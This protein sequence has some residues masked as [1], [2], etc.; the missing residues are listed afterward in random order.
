[1]PILQDQRPSHYFSGRIAARRRLRRQLDRL[2]GFLDADSVWAFASGA[3]H[4]RLLAAESQLGVTLPWELWELLRR[5]N[6]Q[7][8]SSR[9]SQFVGG[10]RLLSLE[11][12]T[13]EAKESTAADTKTAAEAL[14]TSRGGIGRPC[15]LRESTV[16]RDEA[17][18]WMLPLT[19]EGRGKKRYTV[20]LGGRVW[21]RSGFNTL[22]A[23]ESLTVLIQR[24]LT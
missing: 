3:H 15:S 12:I 1:M 23:A 21:L 17:P 9:I 2:E 16:G 24:E 14:H 11:E 18:T 5:R 20:D 10:L 19:A 22:F 13:Q 8:P 7:D 6:G 4:T